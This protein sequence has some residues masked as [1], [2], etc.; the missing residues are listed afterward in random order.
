MTEV[1]VRAAGRLIHL[2]C[3]RSLTFGRDRGCDV[4]LD[5]ADRGISR[6]AGSIE[7][8][9]GT[10]WVVNHSAKRALHVVDETRLALPL[11]VNAEGWPLSRQAI[12]GRRITVLVAGELW[13]HELVVE[14][15][16][17]QHTDTAS[18]KSAD[19]RST[20]SHVPTLTENRR[21][22]LVA[23]ASG[24]LRPHPDYDP[25]PLGYEDAAALLGIKGTQLR[26]RIEQIRGQ[27]TDAGVTGLDSVDARR[28]LCEW[29]LAMRLISPADLSLLPP[30]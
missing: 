7:H 2:P 25:R 27:L 11:P 14:P 6:V 28:A 16:G 9:A 22:A 15:V 17:T 10:W 20:I 23:L 19:P 3:D 12:G 29:S 24:Y 4:C 30:A 1:R 13:T 18:R 5:P 26:K 21:A 8:Q